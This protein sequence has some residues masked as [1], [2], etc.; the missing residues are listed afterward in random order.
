MYSV[1]LEAMCLQRIEL[2]SSI[3]LLTPVEGNYVFMFMWVWV[4]T[5][6]HM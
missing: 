6:V 3:A 4:Y 2:H 5:C 1:F